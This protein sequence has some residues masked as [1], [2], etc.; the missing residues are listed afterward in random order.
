MS[1]RALELLGLASVA[2]LSY[3]L[4]AC[5]G[6]AIDLDQATELASAGASGDDTVLLN[7]KATDPIFSDISVDDTRLYWVNGDGNLQSCVKDN[8]AHSVT[9][10]A[11]VI[12][13]SAS[14]WSPEVAVG[15]GHVYW[16]A[17]DNTLYSCPSSGCGNAPTKVIR[18]SSFPLSYGQTSL[19]ADADYVYWVSALDLYRCAPTGCGSAPE[20]V[21]PE[22]T[23]SPT[24]SSDNAYWVDSDPNANGVSSSDIKNTLRTAPK[25]GSAPPTTVLTD[26]VQSVAAD[27]TNVYWTNFSNHVLRCPVSGCTGSPLVVDASDTPKGYL[28]LDDSGLYWREDPTNSG[29]VH[30]CPLDDCDSEVTL[31]P[32]GV[33][34]FAVDSQYLYWVEGTFGLGGTAIHR[35]AK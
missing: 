27:E 14:Q 6:R 30:F 29:A 28:A 4:Q 12:S 1:T 10:Y 24:Y 21:A 25:D 17:N 9:T 16:F 33:Q 31:T 23:D 34:S 18:D 11:S 35:V 15:G 13:N 32:A 22:R 5:S 3:Y 20:I 19:A 26:S 2:L 7:V 8:C